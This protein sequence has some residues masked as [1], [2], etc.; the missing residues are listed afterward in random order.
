MQVRIVNEV[1]EAIADGDEDRLKAAL[2]ELGTV[3]LRDEYST[4][5]LEDLLSILHTDRARRY[6]PSWLVWKHFEENWDLLTDTSRAALR[7]AVEDE[8]CRS[9]HWMWSFTIAILL[10]E[11]FADAF[12]M[13]A[14][15]RFRKSCDLPGRVVLPDAIRNLA[16][17]TSDDTVRKIA[18]RELEL[19]SRDPL[20]QVRQEATRALAR[21]R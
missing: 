5:V 9:E 6:E 2:Y 17:R 21:L 4:K 14:F 10:A 12:A 3:A 18:R 1:A 20:D 16:S 19:L 15:V 11:C 7:R 8:F 13:D